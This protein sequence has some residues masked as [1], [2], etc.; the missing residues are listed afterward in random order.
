MPILCQCDLFIFTESE[1]IPELDLGFALSASS[2]DAADTIKLM[3]GAV[4]SIIDKYGVGKKIRYGL[5]LFGQT[6]ST[7]FGFGEQFS[8]TERIKT[9]VGLSR[10]P[11]GDP[12]VV[13]SLKESKKVRF[14]TFA[15]LF[16]TY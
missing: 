15:K 4:T 13:K 10:R 14:D 5:I 8:S 16:R 11:S 6:S 7:S 1:L 2:I 3:K 9:F 12:D